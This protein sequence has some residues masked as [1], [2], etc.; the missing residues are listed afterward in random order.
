MAGL[1]NL[2]QYLLPIGLGGAGLYGGHK[3]NE[4]RSEQEKAK[5]APKTWVPFTADEPNE[6]SFYDDAIRQIEK[7]PYGHKMGNPMYHM[8]RGARK[9]LAKPLIRPAMDTLRQGNPL[10]G[11][12]LGG[13]AGAPI[14]LILGLIRNGFSGAIPG[15]L[16]GLAVGAIGGGGVSALG[17]YAA[18]R[19]FG[20]DKDFVNPIN[21]YRD[22]I[23]D[24]SN[25]RK[26]GS[27]KSAYMV[28]AS[29]GPHI[30]MSSIYDSGVSQAQ[31]S[32]LA[33]EMRAL[34]PRQKST[35]QRLLQGAAGSAA[36][37]IIAKY[38]LGLG[39]KTTLMSMILG[40]LGGYNYR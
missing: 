15:L 26:E 38:L 24:K 40:G 35:L 14:G 7:A 2:S 33:A 12:A 27:V 21:K 23:G 36:I 4:Y 10:S 34:N 32:A 30:R 5:N 28:G 1:A 20:L 29:P 16:K 13:L 9:F 11:A 31:K 39:K 6:V 19:D 37:F 17:N 8:G 25:F 22:F 3:I 18:N